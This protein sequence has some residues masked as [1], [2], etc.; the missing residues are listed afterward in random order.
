MVGEGGGSIAG[1]ELL[2]LLT[3]VRQH[4]FYEPAVEAKQGRW[5]HTGEML[6]THLEG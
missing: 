6:T 5:V 3:A 1:K 4:S 2:R